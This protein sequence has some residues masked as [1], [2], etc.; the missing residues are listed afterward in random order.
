[1]DATAFLKTFQL[2]EHLNVVFQRFE[3]PIVHF[4]RGL[5]LGDLAAEVTQINREVRSKLLHLIDEL[6]EVRFVARSPAT[7]QVRISVQA[8]PDWCSFRGRTK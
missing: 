5:A 7:H 1:M 8:E 3:L 2:T 6:L 4:L